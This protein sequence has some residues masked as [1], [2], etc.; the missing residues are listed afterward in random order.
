MIH[1]VEMSKVNITQLPIGP[2]LLVLVVLA[3]ASQILKRNK[4]DV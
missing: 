3:L 1:I 2:L 4:I